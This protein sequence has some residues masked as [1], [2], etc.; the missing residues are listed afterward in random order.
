MA[1]RP[2]LRLADIDYELPE[3]A[4]AQVPVEPREAARMLVV[5]GEGYA[6][7]R[8]HDLPEIL[9][10]GDV[11]VAN[12]TRV[13]AARVMALRKGGGRA[14]VLFLKPASAGA[15]EALVRPSRKLPPG[16]QVRAGETAI[17]LGPVLEEGR[18]LVRI[19]EGTVEGLLAAVGEVPLPPYV[20]QP[21][22][23]RERYQTVYA[24]RPGSSAA[25]T[26]GLH[27]TAGLQRRL[28]QRGVGWATVD[29]EVGIDTFRP[30]REEDPTRHRMH[31]ERYEVSPATVGAIA[32]ARARG[33]RVMAVG[34]TTVR[35]L[36][37]AASEGGLEAGAGESR[38][39]IRPGYAFSV[40]DLLLTNF[41]APRSTLLLL[42]AAVMGDRWREAY[43][44]ALSEGYRFLSLGDAMLAQVPR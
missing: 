29:L 36:E 16:S 21:L 25:P 9:Q 13:R 39:Y 14:E 30:V 15:W 18:R 32:E 33:G 28:A 38:L 8:V 27:I 3:A 40:V 5:E 42:L 11:V 37:S 26:A 20:R 7:R 10:P 35:A 44:V 2:S 24:R 41:H 19:L 34:T 43:R 17:E 22:P 4:V 23:D 6:H 1:R 31:A 12:D